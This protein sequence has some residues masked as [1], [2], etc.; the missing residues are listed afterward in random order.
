ML[1]DHSPMISMNGYLIAAGAAVLS[2]TFFT[3]RA[4]PTL[5]ADLYPMFCM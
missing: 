4:R 5:W 3:Y 2:F 1:S